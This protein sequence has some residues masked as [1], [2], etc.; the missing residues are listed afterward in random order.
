MI[1]S[2][3]KVC[4]R[5]NP[6]F[7]LS[8]LNQVAGHQYTIIPWTVATILSLAAGLKAHQNWAY[9]NGQLFPDLLITDLEWVQANFRI[10]TA[11]C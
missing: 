2:C 7:G 4:Y 10:S 3:E 9:P 1:L 5:L 6:G 8:S 11:R